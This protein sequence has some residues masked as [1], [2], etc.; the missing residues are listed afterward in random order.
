[1]TNDESPNVYKSGGLASERQ[2]TDSSEGHL[3]LIRNWTR[4]AAN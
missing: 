2:A 3:A 1:M 4:R